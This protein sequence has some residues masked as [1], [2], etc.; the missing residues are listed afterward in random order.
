MCHTVFT[1]WTW[2]ENHIITVRATYFLNQPIKKNKGFIT[3]GLHS[4][5]VFIGWVTQLHNSGEQ[6]RL[7][8]ALFFKKWHS[9]NSCLPLWAC[10]IM[11]IYSAQVRKGHCVLA[12]ECV[13]LRELSTP[14]D[15]RRQR[16]GWVR[17]VWP[18][19]LLTMCALRSKIL[20]CHY[21]QLL[22][23]VTRKK[24]LGNILRFGSFSSGALAKCGMLNLEV[25]NVR[26]WGNKG[27]RGGEG[28][29]ILRKQEKN[30]ICGC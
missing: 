9:N 27:F 23:P 19:P 10:C 28:T 2:A 25:S 20:F 18:S 29:E 3:A 16:C 8:T 1:Y 4:K 30:K 21:R 26:C 11:N 5:G 12:K 6:N 13:P 17:A 7:E 24:W 15:D 22:V 14:W